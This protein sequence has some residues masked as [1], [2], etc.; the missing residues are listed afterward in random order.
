MNLK[1][2]RIAW[3]ILFVVALSGLLALPLSPELG[4]ASAGTRAVEGTIESALAVSAVTIDGDGTDA[5]WNDATALTVTVG[6]T[7]VEIKTAYTSTEIFFLATW[8]DPT[9]SVTKNQWSYDG[10]SDEWTQGGGNEDRLSFVWDI[11]VSNFNDQGGLILCHPPLMRTETAGEVVDTWHWKSVRTNPSGWMDDKYWNST[12]RHSDS[13]TSGGYSDNLQT[14]A[15]TDDPANSADIPLY[16]EP[17]ASGDDADS[18]LQSEIDGSEAKTIVGVYTNGTL[19][20]DAGT[21]VSNTTLIPGFYQSRPAGSRGDIETAGVF[22]SGEWTLEWKRS[23]ET[24]STDDIQFSD[25]SSTAEYF[26]AVAVFDNSGGSDH[27]TTGADVFRLVFEQPNQPPSTPSTTASSTTADV[28]E[29]ITFDATASD[30][31]GDSLTYSWEFGDGLEGSGSSVTHS[32]SEAGTYTVTVTASDG[33]G[34]TSEASMDVTISE[35]AAE[36]GFPIELII[37]LVVLIAAILAIIG[38]IAIRRRRTPPTE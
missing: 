5:A 15:F 17:G 8:G 16:W 21:F 31:D 11:S 26:F 4:G 1:D 32:Y 37:A 24:G 27:L 23:L 34:G 10:P 33:R 7:D 19:L 28:D 14:L 2:K 6:S 20:D 18:I 29:T 38:I 12:G 36:A 25:T 35:K 22:G 9:E 3:P 13:K 30:P